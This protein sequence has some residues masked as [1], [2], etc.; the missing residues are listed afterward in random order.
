[1]TFLMRTHICC[2]INNESSRTLEAIGKP[3]YF[4]GGAA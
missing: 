2:M 1:V 3:R 4:T